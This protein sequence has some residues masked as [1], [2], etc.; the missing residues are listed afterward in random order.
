MCMHESRVRAHPQ[1]LSMQAHSQVIKTWFLGPQT[2]FFDG[3][4]SLD[5]WECPKVSKKPRKP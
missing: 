4:Q 1:N 2:P 3:S 5:P